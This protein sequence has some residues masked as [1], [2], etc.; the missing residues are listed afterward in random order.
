ME[1]LGYEDVIIDLAKEQFPG[2]LKM[3]KTEMLASGKYKIV[4]PDGGV[5]Y[6]KNLVGAIGNV[7]GEELSTYSDFS[8]SNTLQGR[9]SGLV[10]RSNV[11][12]LGNN[13]ATLYVRGL[14]GY[15]NNNA[16]VIVDGIE[17]S[18]DDIIPEEVET[19]DVLKDATAKILYG[20]RAA[21]GGIM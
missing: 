6:Q 1:A 3:K 8:L 14:H 2:V 15:T 9:V 12:G 16:I 20:A 18:M 19:I 7:T 5:T 21:N 13:T 11:N 10:V 17:R 4:R